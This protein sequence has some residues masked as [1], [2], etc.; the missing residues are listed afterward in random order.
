MG[1]LRDLMETADPPV[2][3]FNRL[4]VAAKKNPDWPVDSAVRDRSLATLFSR[5]D[6]G[7]DLSWL[8]DR[9][10]VQ[11]AL[12]RT[13]GV[14]L[15]PIRQALGARERA[16]TETH[17]LRLRDLPAAR[18]LDL[19]REEL[20][21]GI[22][23]QLF[24]APAEPIWW[25]A[26]SGAGRGLLGR[27]LAARGWAVFI[28]RDSLEPASDVPEGPC[29]VELSGTAPRASL[30]ARKAL[31]VAAAF[32]PPAGSGFQHVVSPALEQVLAPLLAWARERLPGDTR[33]DPNAAFAFFEQRVQAGQLATLGEVLGV[34]GLVDELGLREVSTRSF[35]KVAQ[36]FVEQRLAKS[37]DPALPF[38][39][40]LKRSLYP[41]LVGIAERALVDAEI[42]LE[43][44]RSFEA[45]LELVPPELERNVDLEW[46]RLSLAQVDSGIRPADLERAARKLPPGA[47]R[48]VTSLETAGILRRQRGDYL[49]LGPAWL[50]G[51]LQ[52]KSVSAVLLRSPFEWGEALLRP[53]AAP[54]LAAALLDRVMAEG[55]T[56]LEPVLDLESEDQP[57]YAAAV[58]LALRVAGIA[59]LLGADLSQELL[60]GLWRENASLVLEV[61]GSP[62]LPRIELAREGRSHEG[63]GEALL[64]PGSFYLAA[65]SVS[66][67]LEDAVAARMNA[68]NPWRQSRPSAALGAAYDLIW[69]SLGGNPPWRSAAFTLIQSVRVTVG[70][71]RNPDDPHCLELPAQVLDEVQHG[72]LAFEGVERLQ[73]ELGDLSP[74]LELA[75]SR[76]VPRRE[77]ARA[78]WNAWDQA[79]RPDSAPFLSPEARHRALFWSSIPG[80]LLEN[81]LLDQRRGRIPYEV[82]GDEQWEAYTRALARSPELVTDSEAWRTIP[83]GLVPRALLLPLAWNRAPESLSVLWLR[84]PELLAAACERQLRAKSQADTEVL[85][86]LL[87]SAPDDLATS[88]LDELDTL[89]VS[90]SPAAREALRLWLRGLVARRGPRFREAYRAL[91]RLE[92]SAR[93]L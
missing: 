17:L 86:A 19:E 71:V 48:I 37:L 58:D 7:Q 60:A 66:E 31:W 69:A 56:A 24:T 40:W 55:S 43:E 54:L 91:A 10:A 80:S 63:R 81:L 11:V 93:P 53:Q 6:R 75:D 67:G 30:Q 72:V 25:Q 12:A 51:Y 33:F 5:L 42:T 3:S 74:L 57:G 14:P 2:R 15:D 21:P 62:P 29:F 49:Q 82:F 64:H 83:A 52:R 79:E 8:A 36:R 70:N 88:V 16:D 34:V 50:R 78:V 38:A 76:H 4:A 27:W 35:D 89:S 61:S 46:M 1:W 28:E 77:V 32:P 44:P 68:L 73:R 90:F 45:W 47:F 13:L 23:A 9:H 41:A 39:G 65:L 59:R 87:T 20:P 18:P 85:V 22:P 92:R 26:A 84:F